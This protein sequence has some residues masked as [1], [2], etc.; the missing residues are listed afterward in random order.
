VHTA[1]SFS[2]AGLNRQPLAQADVINV[3]TELLIDHDERASNVN[4]E[5][6]CGKL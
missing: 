2:P 3:V 4:S 1:K 6:G 5:M